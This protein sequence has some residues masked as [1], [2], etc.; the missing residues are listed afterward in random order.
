MPHTARY[1]L[2]S[3]DEMLA[4]AVA[5]WVAEH[6]PR[7]RRVREKDR[8]AEEEEVFIEAA[9]AA[10]PPTLRVEQEL[11]GKLLARPEL[12]AT[13]GCRRS[14]FADPRHR[15]IFLYS[16]ALSRLKQPARGIDVAELVCQTALL[17]GGEQLTLIEELVFEKLGWSLGEYVLELER[18]ADDVVLQ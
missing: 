10:L 13:I 3:A 2:L 1:L 7:A 4:E 15:E 17:A 18:R 5:K 9:F 14:D 11:L 6:Q 16:Y 8:Q 12:H